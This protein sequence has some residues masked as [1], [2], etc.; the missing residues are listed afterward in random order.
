MVY[1]YDS[2]F[3]P[4]DQRWPSALIILNT[5]IKSKNENGTLSGVLGALW[6]AS[7]Y[8]ICAD[9]GANRLYDATVARTGSE[10]PIGTADYFP[11]LI[12]GDLDSL[13]PD[14]RRYYEG[15]GVSIV[16]V[17]DQ[18]FHDLDVSDLSSETSSSFW[19]LQCFEY[20]SSLTFIFAVC[21]SRFSTKHTSRSRSWP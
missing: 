4:D 10:A 15:R 19:H 5:P 14:V 21:R 11:H 12:T 8:R 1:R 2:P 9:G 18:N 16:R 13:R 6:E 17:E 7:S 20:V 3:F